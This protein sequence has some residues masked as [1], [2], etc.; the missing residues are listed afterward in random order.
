M[1]SRSLWGMACKVHDQVDKA[2]AGTGKDGRDGAGD[3]GLAS[4]G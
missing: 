4:Y 3:W 1:R 2:W